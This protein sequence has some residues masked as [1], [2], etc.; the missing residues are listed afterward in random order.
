MDKRSLYWYFLT[1]IFT[2]QSIAVVWYQ[3]Q[4]ASDN[5][6]DV[7]KYVGL[8]LNYGRLGNQLFH[9]ITGYGIARTLGRIHYLPFENARS[10]VLNYL[11]IFD[12][13]FPELRHTYVLSTNDTNQTLIAFAGSCC[14]YDNPNRLLNETAEYLLLNFVYGQNPRYFDKYLSEIRD[15]LRF[16]DKVRHEGK[17]AMDVLQ[18][19]G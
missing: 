7:E 16:S 15:L 9:L 17:L 10:H 2:I 5:N 18:S 11:K 13:A 3:L 19:Y 12:E 6:Q 1:G 14:A 8:H 4:L